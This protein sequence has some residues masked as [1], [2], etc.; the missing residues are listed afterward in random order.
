MVTAF[1]RQSQSALEI[2]QR[3]GKTETA[4]RMALMR[5]RRGLRGCIERRLALAAG[6]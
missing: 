5:V 1:Y 6:G 3:I 2:G 4:V